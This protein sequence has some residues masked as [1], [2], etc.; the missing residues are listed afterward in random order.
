MIETI[1]SDATAAH[2]QS[3]ASRHA[4]AHL[5]GDPAVVSVYWFPTDPNERE[6]RL[7]E[8]TTE[9]P[10]NGRDL[11]PISFGVDTQSPSAHVLSIIDCSEDEIGLVLAGEQS[12]PSGWV[13][14]DALKFDPAVR[15]NGEL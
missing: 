6:V 13:V 5:D 9:P 10:L 15:W 11:E 2:L 3:L 8:V 12:L 1:D 14:T 7:L 4:K